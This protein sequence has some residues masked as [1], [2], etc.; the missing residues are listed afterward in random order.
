MK[1]IKEAYENLSLLSKFTAISSSILAVILLILLV[2]SLSSCGI[3]KGSSN[4]M[5][6][7]GIK[8]AEKVYPDDNFIEERIEDGIEAITGLDLDLSPCTPEGK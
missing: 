2:L 8:V 1:N 3:V 5:I 4:S 6:D 7:S